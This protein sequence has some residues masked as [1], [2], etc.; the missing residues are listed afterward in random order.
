MVQ[1][2][3]LDKVEEGMLLVEPTEE[4]DA[5]ELQKAVQRGASRREN[6][7]DEEVARNLGRTSASVWSEPRRCVGQLRL[8]RKF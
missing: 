1:Y 2:S 3:E 4:K 6:R 8:L 5:S 7:G